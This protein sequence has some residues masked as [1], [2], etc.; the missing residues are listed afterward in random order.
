MAKLLLAKLSGRMAYGVAGVALLVA[1]SACKS[2]QTTQAGAVG[3][4]RK[5]SMSRLVTEDQLRQSAATQYAQT[6]GEARTKGSLNAD[7]ALTQ[8]VRGIAQRLIPHTAVYRADAPKWAWE[9]NVIRSDELN[10]WCM[11][12][13]KIAFY[14][15]IIQ[16]LNLTDDEIAAIMGHE[17]AHA[18]REHARERVSE[19]VTAGIGVQ[20]VAAATGAG[21]AGAEIGQMLYNVT[22]SLP[23]SRTHET[24]ADRMGVE[25]AA[26]GGFNPAAAVD[27]WKKMSAVSQGKGPQFLSSHPSNDQRIADLTVY[28]QRVMPLYQQARGR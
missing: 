10:A 14:T 8:R 22:F 12:G 20:V 28:A 24:E 26:R 5:Q 18:L 2:V 16:R 17:I 19:Q 25:L 6:M 27:L 1:L 13:G 21:Q 3:V 11:P 15:G 9:V 4:E 23:N 7:A